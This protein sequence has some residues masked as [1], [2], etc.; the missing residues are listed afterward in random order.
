MEIKGHP[1]DITGRHCDVTTRPL[2]SPV[3]LHL[4]VTSDATQHLSEASIRRRQLER[5]KLQ[6]LEQRREEQKRKERE[7]EA[8]RRAGQR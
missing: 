5:Q 8:R 4:Q 1:H 7:D 6:E 2:H 3:L